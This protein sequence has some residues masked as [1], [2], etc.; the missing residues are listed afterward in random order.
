MNG[1]QLIR[2]REHGRKKARLGDRWHVLVAESAFL[3]RD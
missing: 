2:L 3:M 1:R